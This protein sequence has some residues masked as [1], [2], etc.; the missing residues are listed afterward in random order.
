MGSMSIGDR[1]IVALIAVA[2]LGGCDVS[3]PLT[4]DRLRSMSDEQVATYLETNPE[5]GEAEYVGFIL[6]PE[7][8]LGAPTGV[9]ERTLLIFAYEECAD[10]S[11]TA[12][13]EWRRERVG[14]PV[15][16]ENFVHTARGFAHRSICPSG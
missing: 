10:R 5:S 7:A 4:A 12:P 14:E 11:P 15:G 16:F 8:G 6:S 3:G 9:T 2:A 1:W 13:V